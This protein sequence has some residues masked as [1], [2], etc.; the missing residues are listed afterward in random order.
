MSNVK[1]GDVVL[2]KVGGKIYNAL[3]HAVCATEASHLGENGEP[4]LHLSYL[5]DEPVVNGKPKVPPI[6]Y[7]PE[8]VMIHGVVHA[9]HEFSAEYMRSHRLRAV[10]EDDPQKIQAE[11]E[12]RNRRGA[13]EWTLPTR[14]ALS[15]SYVKSLQDR[16][17]AEKAR[18]DAAE[19]EL[20][21]LKAAKSSEGEV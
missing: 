2:L 15:P 13:G 11:T 18:A 4:M 16:Y 19:A 3:V 6:G 17:A 21:Q 8:S 20:A 10:V 5:P 14:Q 12:I 7:I 1:R 9:S